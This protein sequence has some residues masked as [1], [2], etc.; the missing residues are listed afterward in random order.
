MTVPSPL[1]A[2]ARGIRRVW[3]LATTRLWRHNTVILPVAILFTILNAYDAL[4]MP[5]RNGLVYVTLLTASALG[6]ALLLPLYL[7]AGSIFDSRRFDL[8]PIPPFLIFVLRPIFGNPL[9]LLLT[10]SVLVWCSV[11]L[12]QVAPTPLRAALA[13]LQLVGLVLCGTIAVEILEDLLRR[14]SS[15]VL[16]LL[17][18]CAG[19]VALVVFGTMSRIRVVLSK[20]TLVLPP[21]VTAALLRQTDKPIVSELLAAI[22]PFVVAAFLLALAKA[23]TDGIAARPPRERAV[24][25]LTSPVAVVAGILNPRSP[26]SFGKELA[27]T[28]RILTF[29][30][31]H[32]WVLV[33]GFLA[34]TSGTP[35]VL[36][37]SFFLW[38]A[39]AYNLL[40]PDVPM[41]GLA[42]YSLLP[43]RIDTVLRRRHAAVVV[44]A[45]GVTLVGLCTAAALHGRLPGET[46]LVAAGYLGWLLYAAST[47]LLSTVT[48]DWFS[49][50]Q[51]RGISVRSLMQRASGA[52]TASM[53]LTL[54]VAYFGTYVLSGII[55]LLW[56]AAARRIGLQ[57]G[58]GSQLLLVLSFT[59]VTQYGVYLSRSIAYRRR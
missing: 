2:H 58:S 23:I 17:V 19:F 37:A 7:R 10:A 41:G 57:D 59:T 27:V 31:C 42:R 29:W 3:W 46:Y 32:V 38:S 5:T 50:R 36:A 56:L 18:L 4:R 48:G 54:F 9:R 43:G 1:G 34:A 26:G 11:G 51:P 12:A 39:A 16:S 21:A 25:T 55:A 13:I 45:L 40:G 35:S 8:L 47:F 15:M 20:E 49:M 52:G 30:P 6:T 33:A 14:W 24:Y 28:L 22:V 44:T 53:G